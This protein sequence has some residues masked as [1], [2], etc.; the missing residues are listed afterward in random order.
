MEEQHT[1]PIKTKSSNTVPLSALGW[2][3]ELDLPA[4]EQVR[5][6]LNDKETHG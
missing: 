2:M 5:F 4:L 6:M 1:K 3:L